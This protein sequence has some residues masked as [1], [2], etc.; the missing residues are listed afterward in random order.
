MPYV[1]VRGARNTLVIPFRRPVRRWGMRGLGQTC[2]D[3]DTGDPVACP[4]EPVDVVIP[5]GYTPTPLPNLP[6]TSS[7]SGPMPP[8]GTSVIGTAGLCAPGYV[9]ADA[10]GNCA[11]AA[12]VAATLATPAGAAAAGLSTSA[13]ASIAAAITAGAGAAKSVLAPTSYIVP[14]TATAAT[15]SLGGIPVTYWAIGGALLFA[16]ALIGGKRR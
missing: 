14:G 16:L 15:S 12:Q 8:T 5:E 7:I 4:E 11:P 3:P 13:A 1:A 2:T 6:N 10:S 9:I